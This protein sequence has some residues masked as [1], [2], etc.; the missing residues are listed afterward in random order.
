MKVV[1]FLQNLW[2][3]D[4]A[5]VEKFFRRYPEMRERMLRKL[6]FYR[7]KTGRVLKAGLGEKLCDEIVWEESTTQIAGDA[8]TVFPPDHKHIEDVIKKHQPEVVIALGK[9]AS[10][11]VFE[12]ISESM[13]RLMLKMEF[14]SAPHP[15]ARPPLDPIGR[16]KEIRAKIESHAPEAHAVTTGTS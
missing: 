8:R 14:C 4:P 2:V 16:L 1:A 6:L 13:D 10:Q 15:C 9:V 12:V 3:K 7:C 11:A 5:H